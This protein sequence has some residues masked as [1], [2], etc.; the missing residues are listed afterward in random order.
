MEVGYVQAACTTSASSDLRRR[1]EMAPSS[2]YSLCYTNETE[3]L[4]AYEADAASVFA[5]TTTSLMIRRLLAPSVGE[6]LFWCSVKFAS[7]PAATGSASTAPHR[8]DTRALHAR[9]KRSN[10]S[11]LLPLA[12]FHFQWPHTRV[13]NFKFN[14]KNCAGTNKRTRRWEAGSQ[15]DRVQPIVAVPV[16]CEYVTSVSFDDFHV[17]SFVR[18]ENDHGDSDKFAHH[19]PLMVTS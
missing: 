8:V 4:H 9:R 17:R 6:D 14:A 10:S 13:T 18:F 19:L 1:K 12:C 16:R 11:K 15:Q 2:L 7:L 3:P 5:H